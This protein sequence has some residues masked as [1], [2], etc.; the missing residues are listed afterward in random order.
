[1]HYGL[2][3]PDGWFAD[4]IKDGLIEGAGRDP[5]MG[6]S[7]N[8]AYGWRSYRSALQLVRLRHHGFVERDAIQIRMFISGYGRV[9]DIRDSLFRQYEKHGRSLVAQVR[10]GYV[11]NARQIPPG[12]KA[13]LAESLEP[14]DSRLED[15]GLRLSDDG[16]IEGI[17]TAKNPPKDWEEQAALWNHGIFIPKEISFVTLAMQF[18]R[19]LCGLLMFRS[20]EDGSSN[21]DFLG[22]LVLGSTDLQYEKAIDFYFTIADRENLEAILE[23]ITGDVG[24]GKRKAAAEAIARS[25]RNN[26]RWTAHIL[27]M[28]LF[29]ARLGFIIYTPVQIRVGIRKIRKDGKNLRSV[30]TDRTPT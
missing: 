26:P 4:L 6:L 30:V 21:H 8:Y 10:S 18:V 11:D 9:R 27:V 2:D 7:P 25:I 22:N 17:R 14:L 12:H 19:F 13:K 15:A 1:V 28:G 20:K 5:N 3:L 23:C 29:L 24:A 16:Y